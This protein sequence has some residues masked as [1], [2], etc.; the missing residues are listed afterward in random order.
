MKASHDNKTKNGFFFFFA[1]GFS[2]TTFIYSLFSGEGL[3]LSDGSFYF[4]LQLTGKP[5]HF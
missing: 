3:F 2:C 1:K 5:E 4:T